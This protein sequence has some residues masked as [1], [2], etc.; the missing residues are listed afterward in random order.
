MNCRICGAGALIEFIKFDKW[1][2]KKCLNCGHG[3]THPLPDPDEL[4]KLYNEKYFNL[5]YE[6]I[7][8]GH[9]SFLKKIKQENSRVKFLLSSKKTGNLLDIG[10]GK[11][12]FLYACKKYFNCTG[13]D[14]SGANKEFICNTLNLKLEISSWDTAKFKKQSFDAI[15]LWHSL[16]HIED[17]YGA[18]NK[19]A[20][21]LK[22]DGII[23]I[24]VPNHGGTDGKILYNEWP[25]WDIPFHLHHYTRE[26][27]FLLL[28]K[29]NFTPI[30]TNTY[31]SEFIKDAL[32]KNIYT[33]FIARLIAKKF[34][35]NGIAVLCKKL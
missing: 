26:S 22:Q 24:E 32:L 13:F 14:I 28:D 30:K 3:I 12:Y 7:Q 2:V 33:R 9:K 21:W 25:D 11:G 18:L 35:G 6:E 20:D 10:C 29:T 27:L 31:H 34:E 15:T 19:C 5:H 8:P 4:D 23:I 17:P 1:T 16:E